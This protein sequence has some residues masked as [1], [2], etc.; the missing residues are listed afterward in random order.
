MLHIGY[1]Y[2]EWT[3]KGTLTRRMNGDVY[4]FKGADHNSS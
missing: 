3:L 2:L 4:L 1:V